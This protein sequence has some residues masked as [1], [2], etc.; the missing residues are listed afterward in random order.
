M[1]NSESM[2]AGERRVALALSGVFAT[3]M[4][5]LF[6]VLPVFAYY[7]EN[8]DGSTLLLAG[9]AVGIYGLTQSVFQIPLGRLSDKVG[10]KPIIIAGLLVFAIG[11]VI[12]AMADSI[13]G[14]I[15]GRAL[16]GAGAIAG[17]VMAMA[18]DLTR[19]EHRLKVMASIG[20]SIGLAFMVAIVIGP[21]LSN[22]FGVAGV[23]WTTAL[24]AIIAIFI[25]I[26]VVPTPVSTRFHRDTEVEF[27]W[28]KRV[29]SHSQLVRLDIGVLILHFVMTATMFT[30]PLIWIRQHGFEIADHWRIWLPA[31]ALSVL[32]V[33]P[34]II[35]GEK[36]RQ[37]KQVVVIAVLALTIACLLFWRYHDSWWALAM[38]LWLFFVGFNL[39]EASLPSLVAK[40][41][42]AAHKGTAMGAFSSSQFLGAFLGATTAGWI[43]QYHGEAAVFLVN[44]ILVGLWLGVAMSMRH[45]PY[46]S[47][48]L[49]NVGPLNKAQ[50]RSLAARLTGIRGVAEAIV[51]PEDEVAYLK[52]DKK[53]LDR[54]ALLDYSIEQAE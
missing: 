11:S 34:L 36:K 20:M 17:A 42:P 16:Q 8:L 33:L 29:L 10:R 5:G 1:K 28:L 24:L 38:S 45:P 15:I 32:P 19:E 54:E 23:F 14:V 3:R 53:A 22:W 44:A 35:L 50:A 51:I 21:V 4:L 52:V 46:L 31:M 7:A 48:E 27:N 43:M 6:M 9:V 12:A 30:L 26:F 39:L 2:T 49:L 40:F 13:V 25:I 18:A 41:A 37:L 47:S